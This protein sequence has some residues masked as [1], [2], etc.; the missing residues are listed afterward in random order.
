MS[1][2]LRLTGQAYIMAPLSLSLIPL[3]TY[4]WHIQIFHRSKVCNLVSFDWV[5]ILPKP[6][7][8]SP[9]KT[10]MTPQTH[11]SRNW[12]TSHRL[13]GV[14]WNYVSEYGM[15]GMFTLSFCLSAFTQQN[16]FN[17][18]SC[19]GVLTVHCCYCTVVPW[20][21]AVIQFIHSPGHLTCF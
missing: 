11:A 12:L 13:A 4:N 17:I 3:F 19:L 21:V 18:C 9:I 7:L 2:R 20:C 16:R 10:T 1:H 8:Q 15:W 6:S 14:S 5:A